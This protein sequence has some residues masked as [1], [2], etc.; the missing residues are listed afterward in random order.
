MVLE[1]WCLGMNDR[2]VQ[3]SVLKSCYIYSTHTKISYREHLHSY[4]SYQPSTSANIF[5]SMIPSK[6][7][8]HKKSNTQLK[9]AENLQKWSFGIISDSAHSTT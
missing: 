3:C 6:L 1:T 4:I 8:V 2:Y 7:G 5:L 9:L